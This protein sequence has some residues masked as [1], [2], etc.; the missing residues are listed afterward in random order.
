MNTNPLTCSWIKTV[1]LPALLDLLS[2]TNNP[3]QRLVDDSN[4]HHSNKFNNVTRKDE[5][6]EAG[7]VM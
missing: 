4:I 2:L 6:F 1:L 3:I 5:V 7:K